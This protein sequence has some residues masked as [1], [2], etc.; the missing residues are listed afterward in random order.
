MRPCRSGLREVLADELLVVCA[1]EFHLASTA[2]RMSRPAGGFR[3]R[4]GSPFQR[5]TVP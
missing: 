5:S 4:I 3:F 1:Q 2:H